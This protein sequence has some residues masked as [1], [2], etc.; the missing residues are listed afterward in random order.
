MMFFGSSNALAMGLPV[1]PGAPPEAEGPPP[2]FEESDY[3][4]M[5]R[6]NPGSDVGRESMMR[7]V[8]ASV[9]L[10]AIAD[11]TFF[12]RELPL[13][14]VSLGRPGYR[15]AF[16][17]NEKGLVDV[18]GIDPGM[19]ERARVAGIVLEQELPLLST[20]TQDALAEGVS[21]RGM[22]R[23]ALRQLQS[24][25]YA[26]D[27]ETGMLTSSSGE[28]VAVNL[29]IIGTSLSQRQSKAIEAAAQDL[30]RLGF[31]VQT[32]HS[33]RTLSVMKM[34]NLDLSIGLEKPGKRVSLLNWMSL[35]WQGTPVGTFA[36]E[37]A[38]L[39][40]R[41]ELT[42]YTLLDRYLARSGYAVAIAET[43]PLVDFDTRTER[44]IQWRKFEAL[45]YVGSVCGD[46]SSTRFRN[47]LDG[48]LW[49]DGV[50]NLLVFGLP[51][52][53]GDPRE[54]RLRV[55]MLPS[56]IAIPDMG[57]MRLTLKPGDETGFPEELKAQLPLDVDL[58]REGVLL[59]ITDPFAYLSFVAAVRTVAP[60]ALSRKSLDVTYYRKV[61]GELR[62]VEPRVSFGFLREHRLTGA[63]LCVARLATS[64]TPLVFSDLAKAE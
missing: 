34:E 39:E 24:A 18:G 44:A 26:L 14:E 5:M 38:E 7:D 10:Q 20:L 47:E 11:E 13:Q 49:F 12:P 54:M 21:K 17:E 41:A 4:L 28:T 36:P 9:I 19:V 22:W 46:Y 43:P 55:N 59:N 45:A 61:A 53:G 29:A 37:L 50:N 8:I 57:L 58:Q 15:G 63:P 2:Y 30:L 32:Q 31:R 52:Q 1:I 56:Q 3:Q 33:G 23:Q 6:F 27:T 62:E 51:V 60:L 16:S 35:D 48:M 40:P 64:S 42:A 25:G